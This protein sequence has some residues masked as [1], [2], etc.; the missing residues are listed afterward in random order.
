MIAYQ[1]IKREVETITLPTCIFKVKNSKTSS[2]LRLAL[3]LA[4]FKIS[5]HIKNLDKEKT[6]T[7]QLNSRRDCVFDQHRFLFE[8]TRSLESQINLE[9]SILQDGLSRFNSKIPPEMM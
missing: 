7:Q 2:E 6:E 8:A 4:S 5:E 3:Q 9:V 1:E